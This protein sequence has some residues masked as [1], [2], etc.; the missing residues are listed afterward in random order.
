MADGISRRDFL[1]GV[2]LTIA[3]GVTPAAQLSA[4]PLSYP[5]V[6]TGMRGQHPGSFETAHK[7]R[8][9]EEFSIDGL[10]VEE[11]YDPGPK[12]QCS[13]SKRGYWTYVGRGRGRRRAR[14][15]DAGKRRCSNER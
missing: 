9:G 3:A 6:L 15:A 11:H 10:P 7:F 13:L 1:D 14:L 5:P 12:V 8:D 4:Q 2:A